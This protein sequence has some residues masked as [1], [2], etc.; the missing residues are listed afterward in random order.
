VDVTKAVTKAAEEADNE[1]TP[2][3]TKGS[4][5]RAGATS[6][7]QATKPNVACIVSDE[8]RSDLGTSREN[9]S[10]SILDFAGQVLVFSSI[11]V[12]P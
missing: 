3:R 7:S 5:R 11:S 8:K 1:E 4:K 6:Q 10:G 2:A 12:A 9:R